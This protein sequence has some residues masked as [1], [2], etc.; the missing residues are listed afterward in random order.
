MNTQSSTGNILSTRWDPSPEK[1]FDWDNAESIRIIRKKGFNDI[2]Y[3]LKETNRGELHSAVET[4]SSSNPAAA[5]GRILRILMVE[6][7]R[8][9]CDLICIRLQKCGYRPSVERVE[10]EAQMRAALEREQWDI[11]FTD[12]GLPGFSGQQALALLRKMK[13][14]IPALCITGTQNPEIIREILA[15]GACACLSKDDLSLL[16]GAVERAVSR[17]RTSTKQSSAPDE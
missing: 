4:G 2:R 1:N 6:D 13:L 11:V 7:S 16:C 5:N 3:S 17:C 8:D 10:N 12:H 9:D 14:Q 15:A